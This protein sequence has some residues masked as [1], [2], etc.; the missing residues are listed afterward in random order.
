VTIKAKTRR[1]R[2]ARFADATYPPGPY[3]EV[4]LTRKE[5]RTSASELHSIQRRI[6]LSNCH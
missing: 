5:P 4:E 1:I 6:T 3:Q 2:A